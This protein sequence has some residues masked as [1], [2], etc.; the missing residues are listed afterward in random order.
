MQ[1]LQM[2]LPVGEV[3]KNVLKEGLILITAG[4]NVLRFLPPLIIA[5]RHVDEMAAMLDRILDEMER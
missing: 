5:E 4:S 2:S 1:G 3:S